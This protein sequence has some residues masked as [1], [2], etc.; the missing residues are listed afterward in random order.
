[1]A[2]YNWECV[3]LNWERVEL[4][5]DIIN[6]ISAFETKTHRKVLGVE[7]DRQV[8]GVLEG[9]EFVSTNVHCVIEDNNNKDD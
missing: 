4:E 5:Q 1:M 7:I 3:A 2:D 8:L 9:E 6:A